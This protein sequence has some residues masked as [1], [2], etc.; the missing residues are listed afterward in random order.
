[1]EGKWLDGE[2]Y[3]YEYNTFWLR[4]IP[5]DLNSYRIHLPEDIPEFQFFVDEGTVITQ[6]HLKEDT[7]VYLDNLL[8]DRNSDYDLVVYKYDGW[9]EETGE[10]YWVEYTDDLKTAPQGS[11]LDRNGEPTEGTGYFKIAAKAKEG[12]IYTG[13]TE[14][15]AEYIYMCSNRSISG[16]L[17]DFYYN[18]AYAEFLDEEPWMRYSVNP[19]TSLNPEVE[20][21]GVKLIEGNDY[22]VMYV[23]L[24]VEWI[25]EEFPTEKG[26]YEVF[27]IGQG[28]YYGTSFSRFIKVADDN[29]DFTASG[30]TLKVKVGKKAKKTTKKKTFAKSKAFK[31]SGSQGKVTFKKVSGNS[32]ITVS[33]AGKVTVKKG[34]KKGTYKVKVDVTDSETLEYFAATK[35]VTLKVKV[36]K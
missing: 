33:S 16:Y 23:G 13:E 26:L 3:R 10:T 18:S 14:D 27:L 36:T 6:E 2:D 24:T 7:N 29:D 11:P 35:T 32:K 19:G 34:L 31:T 1:M 17:P 21:N 20:L 9:D 22:R 15:W 12:S 8:L 5:T 30:K 28:E 4:D 25:G